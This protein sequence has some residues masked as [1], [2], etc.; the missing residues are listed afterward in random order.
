VK[1]IGRAQLLGVAVVLAALGSVAL[2]AR[3]TE[4]TAG[5]TR[6]RSD[7]IAVLFNDGAS[8]PSRELWRRRA[9]RMIVV[10]RTT[11]G[12]P[13][14]HAAEDDLFVVRDG[15]ALVLIGGIVRGDR[16]TE[17]GER[18]GGVLSGSATVALAPGDHL[19]IPAGVPHQVHPKGDAAFE[20]LVIKGATAARGRAR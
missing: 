11:P 2:G 19:L 17:P 7:A 4:S 9:W 12:E 18:R 20:Y 13:E 1:Q 5:A 15:E 16:E 3:E 10:R 8:A 6:L 14:V